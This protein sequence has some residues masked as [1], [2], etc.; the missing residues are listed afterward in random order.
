[1]AEYNRLLYVALTRA[2][3]RLVVCGWQTHHAHPPESWYEL[4]RRGFARLPGVTAEPFAAVANPWSGEAMRHAAPQTAPVVARAAA[5][6]AGAEKTPLPAW[7]GQAPFWL[8]GELP[9]EPAVPT[10]LA[11]SRPQDSDLGPVPHA[12]SPLASRD[13]SGSRFRRGKLVHALL[14]HLPDI[15]AAERA[16]A[17][18]TYLR[19]PGAM[20]PPGEVPALLADILAVLENPALAPLFGPDGRAEVPLTGVASGMVVGGLV[21]R[22]AVLPDRVLVADYKTNRL[23][24]ADV[25]SVPVLYLRQM[26]AYRAVLR[27]AFP[28]R[29]IHCALVWTTGA[30]ATVLPDSLLDRH[31]PGAMVAA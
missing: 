15:P 23:P 22:L 19:R 2:E 28:G 8:A 20:I 10:P 16:A 13:A 17:A 30:R 27:G 24:P 11:P 1:M 26:A 18:Q 3:D 5:L 9:P 4:V 6:P 7:A 31:A 12:A 21:D 29:A 14:Q 25:D